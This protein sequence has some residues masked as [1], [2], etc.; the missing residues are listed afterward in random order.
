MS[1]K[2]F[3]VEPLTSLE[4]G[5]QMKMAPRHRGDTLPLSGVAEP[6][7]DCYARGNPRG[8]RRV[9]VVPPGKEILEVF[10]PTATRRLKPSR[11]EPIRGGLAGTAPAAA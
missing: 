5:D 3:Q 2:T 6:L 10:L 8:N 11:T 1:G 7:R 4:A 9:A